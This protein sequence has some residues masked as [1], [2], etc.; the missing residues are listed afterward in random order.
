MAT[1]SKSVVLAV[2]IT[3]ENE[4]TRRHVIPTQSKRTAHDHSM[5]LIAAEVTPRPGYSP[6]VFV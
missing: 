1:S 4:A 2:F 6:G 5:R 3:A